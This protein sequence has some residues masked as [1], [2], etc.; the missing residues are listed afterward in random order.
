MHSLQ[1]QA[2][3]FIEELLPALTVGA[4][5]AGEGEQQVRDLL[6]WLSWFEVLSTKPFYPAT[7]DYDSAPGTASPHTIWTVAINLLL[8]GL[9]T[10]APLELA[11]AAL[12]AHR[13][14]LQLLD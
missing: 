12:A 8:R 1:L 2:G 13:P 6:H 3:Y 7:P 9:P 14:P 11:A 4:T 10:R 5:A